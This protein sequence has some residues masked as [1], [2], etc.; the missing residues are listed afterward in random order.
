[1]KQ[2]CR[3]G[4]LA[5]VGLALA[6][7]GAGPA[8]LSAGGD[9]KAGTGPKDGE[10]LTF[11][12]RTATER[13]GFDPTKDL[14][15]LAERLKKR[16]DPDGL[17]D[18]VIRPAGEGRV[19]IVL[20]PVGTRPKKGKPGTKA[21][22]LTREDLL[23]IKRL[24]SRVGHLE[25]KVLANSHDDA[26]AIAEAREM[27]SKNKETLDKLAGRGEPPPPP[28][29]DGTA[30]GAPKVFEVKLASGARSKVTY[31]WVELGRQV[32]LQL[33]LD[34]AAEKEKGRGQAWKAMAEARAKGIAIQLP[35]SADSP[36][37][38]QQGALFYSREWKDR[39][40]P[41]VERKAKKYEYFVLARNPE[42]DPKTGQ[43]TPNVDGSYLS[44]A[45]PQLAEGRPAVGFTFNAK[46][47][48][49][50]RTL[51]E[52]N[53]PS[54]KEGEATQVK[55]HLAIILD[56]LVVSAPTINSA[57]GQHVQITGNFTPA[58]VRQLVDV[59]R[60]GA[61]PFRLEPVPPKE[62]GRPKKDK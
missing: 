9:K 58:E 59:L 40:L 29:V 10:V 2:P 31:R 52:K 60:S 11:K 27:I 32:R 13:N 49:L 36:R 48:N 34:N 26:R 47:G 14:E 8:R 50:L 56:G 30:L 55:R 20:P 44:S 18:I 53:V 16:I 57:I 4:L 62:G 23:H 25:F 43:P 61:L 15:L 5:V 37:K 41:E 46:G 38:L 45:S 42:I 22:D 12:V 1:M 19:Q 33:G 3:F 6:V 21:R 39:N 24:I 17:Y 51:T 28:T 35:V 54:G 7:S